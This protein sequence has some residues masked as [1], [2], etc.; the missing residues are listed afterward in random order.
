[1]HN[2]TTLVTWSVAAAE[3]DHE[4]ITELVSRYNTAVLRN[5]YSAFF[6]TLLSQK[7]FITMHLDCVLRKRGGPS[8]SVVKT[9][10]YFHPAILSL[11]DS[12]TH[13]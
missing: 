4:N 13:L 6:L 5:F 7:N 2:S 12:F 8:T 9:T 10:P 1:M 3:R 11:R